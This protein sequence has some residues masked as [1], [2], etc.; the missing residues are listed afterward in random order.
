MIWQLEVLLATFWP[1]IAHRGNKGVLGRNGTSEICIDVYISIEE[2][3]NALWV[4]L[5]APCCCFR[6]F[7]CI[8][9]AGYFHE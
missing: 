4:G 9:M 6:F 3:F 1:H 7:G 8:Y 2:P 5:Q